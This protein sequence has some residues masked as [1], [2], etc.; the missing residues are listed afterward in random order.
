M[1]VSVCLWRAPAEHLVKRLHDVCGLG[2]TSF[3]CTK[4]CSANNTLAKLCLL[5]VGEGVLALNITS[6]PVAGGK[7]KWAKLYGYG[8]EG[9][10]N[11]SRGHQATLP[12]PASDTSAEA[13]DLAQT[14]HIAANGVKHQ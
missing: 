10:N 1:Y 9:G 3:P 12:A 8:E 6:R 11:L 14:R 5:G 4:G 13:T 2:Q 7:R